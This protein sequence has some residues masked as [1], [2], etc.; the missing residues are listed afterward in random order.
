MNEQIFD[1]LPAFVGGANHLQRIIFA[2][3]LATRLLD[4]HGF[5]SCAAEKQNGE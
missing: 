1:L 5:G 4:W 2:A 3:I